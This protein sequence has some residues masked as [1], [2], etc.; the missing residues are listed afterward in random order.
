MRKFVLTNYLQKISA[1]SENNGEDE[2]YNDLPKLNYKIKAQNL[3][4]DL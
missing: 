3:P 2:D 4:K 1:L